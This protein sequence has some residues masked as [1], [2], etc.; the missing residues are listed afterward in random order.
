MNT[1]GKAKVP[2]SCTLNP[3]SLWAMS[4]EEAV[5]TIANELPRGNM[6]SKSPEASHC[7]DAKIVQLWP[8]LSKRYCAG[9]PISAQG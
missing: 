7:R 4:L 2:S 5:Q 1:G 6:A 8:M 9:T 3:A